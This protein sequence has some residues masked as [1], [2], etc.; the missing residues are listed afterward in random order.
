MSLTKV[1]SATLN[2]VEHLAADARGHLVVQDPHTLGMC[3]CSDFGDGRH[4]APLI[5]PFVWELFTL[6][7]NLTKIKEPP[8]SPTH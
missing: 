3:S 1:G 8:L 2:A 6:V 7:N 5:Q 4:Y